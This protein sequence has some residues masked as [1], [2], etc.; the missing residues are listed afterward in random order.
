VPVAFEDIVFV[1]RLVLLLRSLLLLLL[2]ALGFAARVLLLEEGS[3]D[4]VEL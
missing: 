3:H 1:D 2:L 4:P